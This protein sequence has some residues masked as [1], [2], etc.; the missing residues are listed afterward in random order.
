MQA[1]HHTDKLITIPGLVEAVALAHNRL[2]GLTEP[3]VVEGSAFLIEFS[4]VHVIMFTLNIVQ[5][6]KL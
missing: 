1:T 4:P 5:C 6:H 2:G 3:V